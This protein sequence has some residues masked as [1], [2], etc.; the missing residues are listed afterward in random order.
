MAKVD[1][2]ISFDSAA[3]WCRFAMIARGVHR[4]VPRNAKVA[5]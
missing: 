5:P 1:L 4:S 3:S 2:S